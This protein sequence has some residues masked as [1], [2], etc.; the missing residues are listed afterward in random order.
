MLEL[1]WHDYI[2]SLGAAVIVVTYLLLQLGRIESDTTTYSTLNALGAALILLS[3]VFV[4]NA[5]A[6]LIELFWLVI[7]ILGVALSIK[8]KMRQSGH[9]NA[10][11]RVSL[12][13]R[14]D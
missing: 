3:L 11:S 9:R 5:A 8:R 1:A 13:K 14:K 7:S 4:F 2:G 12:D 6:F 10:I